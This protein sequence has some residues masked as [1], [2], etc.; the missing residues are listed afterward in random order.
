MG[1][2][3]NFKQ[4]EQL[5]AQYEQIQECKH[6]GLR[7]LE[8]KVTHQDYLLREISCHDQESFKETEGKFRMKMEQ[9]GNKRHVSGLTEVI[10]NQQDQ[11]CM[12]FYK[13]YALFEFPQRTLDDEI[14]ERALQK[15]RFQEKEL[16]SILASCI[17]GMSHLQKNSIRH[18]CLRSSSILLTP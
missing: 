6:Q 10:S 3:P 8:H 12:T 16:W 2:Q 9:L 4:Y 14:N 18:S 13:I 7:Y 5:M 17:L 11:Y 1:N 15:R